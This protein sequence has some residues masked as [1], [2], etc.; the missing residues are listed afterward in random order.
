MCQPLRL[1]LVLDL[2]DV[3]LLQHAM[4]KHVQ[5]TSGTTTQ[6]SML[7]LLDNAAHRLRYGLE[8]TYAPPS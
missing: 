7:S 5:D 6:R 2:G 3:L 1:K 4:Q 8:G